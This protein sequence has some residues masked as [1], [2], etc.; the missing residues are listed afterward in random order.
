MNAR[1]VLQYVPEDLLDSLALEY[2]VDYQVKKLT[3]RSMF[4]LLLF[5]F[6][7]TKETS[8]RVIEQVYHSIAFSKA[9]N[10]VYSGVKY[11]SIRDR[12]TNIKAEYFEAIFKFCLERFEQDLP[13]K[14]N[15]VSFDST[16]VAISSKLLKNGMKLNKKGDKRYLKFTIGFRNI[17]IHV[18]I[19]ND[20]QHL[21]EDLALSE[22]ILA[23]SNKE[24]DIIV[25]D[26]GLQSRKIFE[27]LPPRWF[28]FAI[29]TI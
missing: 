7:T 27:N 18:S 19:F 23:Y 16:M 9:N 17:P 26:R 29:R 13:S 28:G 15:I 6:L 8:Y 2:N 22:A 1:E 3:G 12:L 14:S 20:Q 25:F 24:D 21:S 5:S 10:M 11:N 4:Q